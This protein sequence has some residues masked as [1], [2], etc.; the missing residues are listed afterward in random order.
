MPDPEELGVGR[1]DAGDAEEVAVAL[2]LG[3]A[4]PDDP[5][6]AVDLRHLRRRW[7]GE[8][9]SPNTLLTT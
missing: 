8:N 3:R 7:S 6:D 9:G 4:L 1:V 2:G 5:L